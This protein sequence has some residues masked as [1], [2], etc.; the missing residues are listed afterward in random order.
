MVLEYAAAFDFLRRVENRN[1]GHSTVCLVC[2]IRVQIID[3]NYPHCLR[4]NRSK[5][6]CGH[7][8]NFNSAARGATCPP[9]N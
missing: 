6:R 3:A 7:G 4:K 2:T 8:D 1:N 9:G 5:M